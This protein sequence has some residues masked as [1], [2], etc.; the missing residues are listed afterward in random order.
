MAGTFHL[1]ARL[2]SIS[3]LDEASQ[4]ALGPRCYHREWGDG[5]G[6]GAVGVEGNPLMGLFFF[7]LFCFVCLFV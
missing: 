4:V 7:V 3:Q 6:G 2:A 1:V 5:K